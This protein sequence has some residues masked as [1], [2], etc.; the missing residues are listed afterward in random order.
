MS[1]PSCSSPAVVA[2]S[3]GLFRA[4]DGSSGPPHGLIW[5]ANGLLQATRPHARYTS[6]DLRP[7]G[8]RLIWGTPDREGL[9]GGPVQARAGGGPSSPVLGYHPQPL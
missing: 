7:R 5:G 1:S 6:P 2:H 4:L 3:R 8:A 9:A